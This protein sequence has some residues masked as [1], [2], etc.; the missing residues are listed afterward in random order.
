MEILLLHLWST[1]HILFAKQVVED[2]VCKAL[3]VVHVHLVLSFRQDMDFTAWIRVDIDH[4]LWAIF[5]HPTHWISISIHKTHPNRTRRRAK[6]VSRTNRK[7]AYHAK[8]E[9]LDNSRISI[10]V[11][12]E[13][14]VHVVSDGFSFFFGFNI[15]VLGN[16]LF[17]SFT[18][19]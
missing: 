10:A 3:G 17:N 13:N 5:F 4:L 19:P 12:H 11:P 15:L 9:H 1:N 6:F 8:V 2:D 16:M 18:H 14:L 7:L